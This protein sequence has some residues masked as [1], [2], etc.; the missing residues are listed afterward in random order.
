M[1]SSLKKIPLGFSELSLF[2]NGIF[3]STFI[4]ASG[5]FVSCVF[6]KPSDLSV[7]DR[8]QPVPVD[9]ILQPGCKL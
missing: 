9:Q 3:L 1:L 4:L 8:D 2:P 6:G 7:H 5:S